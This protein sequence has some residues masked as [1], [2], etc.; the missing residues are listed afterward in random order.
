[1]AF[2]PAEPTGMASSFVRAYP[3]GGPAPGRAFWFVFRSGDLL[4]EQHEQRTAL[5]HTEA[6]FLAGALL[7]PPLYLGTLHNVPCLACEVGADA[8][9]PPGLRAVG[10]RALFGAL[11][12]PTY[13]LAGYAA[14]VLYW[15]RTS[16]FCPVCAG[17]TQALGGDWGKRCVVCGHTR[18][19]VVSPAVLALVH[20][21]DRVLLAQKAGWGK[22]YSILAGFVEPGE[23][24]EECV[25]REV[26]EEANVLVDDLEYVGSQPWPYPSQLMVGFTAR[27][28]GGDLR[29]DPSELDD[30]R[31]FR[32][33]ALP[34]LPPL[35]S[36]SRQIIDAW[37]ASRSH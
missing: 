10:L 4:V 34:E 24:L 37:V 32:H 29:P 18:Y 16:R 15:E 27:Y 12:E 9:V 19:P 1:M 3:P 30:A 6:S 8:I 31:W 11:D 7:A 20:D 35:L 5:P 2:A 13:A 26:H 23:S 17:E 25:R 21:G 22:R 28:V 33:D 14:Q 36:L